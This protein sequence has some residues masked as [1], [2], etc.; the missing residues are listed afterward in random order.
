MENVKSLLGPK[1]APYNPTNHDA[2]KIALG[3][4]DLLP[5]DILYDLG[6]GDAR[7]LIEGCKMFDSG[8]R[9]IGVEYDSALCERAIENIQANGLNERITIIHANVLDADF[10]DATAIFIY[11]VPEGIIAI[12]EKLLSLIGRGTR[13]VTYVFSIPD[14]E[15]KK[16]REILKLYVD[17]A[18]SCE[19]KQGDIAR[20]I[21]S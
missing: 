21:S 3:L 11:L 18:Y 6:C 20:L 7:L 1:L 15:P 17:V 19:A 16:M 8:P 5:S 14:L 9:C 12:K 13:V 10:S 2:V 4:L